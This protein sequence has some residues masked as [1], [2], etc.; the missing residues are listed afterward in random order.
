MKIIE[1]E[2]KEKV[3]GGEDEIVRVVKVLQVS[4]GEKLKLRVPLP[5][6]DDKRYPVGSIVEVV[7]F[8]YVNT[9]TLMEEPFFALVEMENGLR[10]KVSL[11]YFPPHLGEIEGFMFEPLEQEA[12]A[13][14]A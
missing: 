9:R 2:V 6:D 14:P 12:V 1:V 5:T 3:K 8:P 10:V 11:Y 7:E 4:E 13:V